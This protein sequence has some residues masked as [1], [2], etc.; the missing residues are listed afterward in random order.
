MS[1]P[2]ELPEGEDPRA[3][4]ILKLLYASHYFQSR[5]QQIG[6]FE[7]EPSAGTPGIYLALLDRVRFDDRLGGPQRL[8]LTRGMKSYLEQRLSSLRDRLQSQYR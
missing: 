3:I 4:V 6:V 7:T 1:R 2:F 8:M 5:F